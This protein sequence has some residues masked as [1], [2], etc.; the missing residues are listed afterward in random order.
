M[1]GGAAIG[2][3]RADG[4]EG[5]AEGD[6]EQRG[7][8]SCVRGVVEGLDDGGLHQEARAEEAREVAEAPREPAGLA[9]DEGVA[10]DPPRD[11]GHAGD[12]PREGEVER[13]GGAEAD[14]AE[15]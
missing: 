11:A 14:A 2:E 10:K 3:A 13:G 4:D 12:V 5:G 1:A 15:K 7:G 8:G 6:G 9:G